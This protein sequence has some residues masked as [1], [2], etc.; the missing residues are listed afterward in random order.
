M[1]A[2]GDKTK[3][4]GSNGPSPLR[5]HGDADLRFFG[6]GAVKALLQRAGVDTERRPKFARRYTFIFVIAW[7][8]LL[9][10]S[11]FQGVAAGD[12]VQIPFANDWS[13]HIRFL[14]AIP[15]FMMADLVTE[16]Q[17]IR[18]IRQF[19]VSDLIPED[20]R[21]NF[22]D[23]A[24]RLAMLARSRWMEVFFAM[25]VAMLA[26]LEI[27]VEPA[28]NTSSW[29]YVTEGTSK[30]L[31]F[32]GIWFYYFGIPLYQFIMLNWMWR[33]LIWFRFLWKTSRIQLKLSGV[34]PDR[35]GGIGFVGISQASFAPFIVAVSTI[36][37]SIVAKEV[38]YEDKL[39]ASFVPEIATLVA[40]FLVVFLA[41]LLVFSPQLVRLR[42]NHVRLH[43]ALGSSV[44]RGFEQRWYSKNDEQAEVLLGTG[45][46]DTMSNM[47]VTYATIK[48]IRAAPIDLVTALAII[49]STLGPMVPLILTV[50]TPAEIFEVIKG[51]IM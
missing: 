38:L 7:L 16:P 48:R 3:Q 29:R 20:E 39:L 22:T 14:V 10:F 24:T 44:A 37:S 26:V 31:S 51:L 33:Y 17:L 27:R 46:V 5:E 45:E 15:L 41:P 12:K 49:G 9:I 1:G 50:Y 36:Y 40:F 32:A 28:L 8:P 23:M 34:H 13:V 6:L 19:H 35:S 4:T 11:T 43:S 18:T 42:V 30:E 2:D 21:Q 47:T 25:L